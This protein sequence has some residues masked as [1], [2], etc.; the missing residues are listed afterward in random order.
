MDYHS[1]YTLWGI[2]ILNLYMVMKTGFLLHGFSKSRGI[3]FYLKHSLPPVSIP[4]LLQG[5]SFY[6]IPTAQ[7]TLG[8]FIAL[9]YSIA[10]SLPTPPFTWPIPFISQVLARR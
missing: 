10:P 2:M 1:N 7:N 3:T 9:L 5:T 6:V 4:S 8:L